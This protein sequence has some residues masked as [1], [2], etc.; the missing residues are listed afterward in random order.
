MSGS[1]ADAGLSDP[2][3]GLGLA[4][5]V[6]I[7]VGIIAFVAGLILLFIVRSKPHEQTSQMVDCN[8]EMEVSEEGTSFE[9]VVMA[10][11]FAYTNPLTADQI[12]MPD[13]FNA[14]GDEGDSFASFFT[15]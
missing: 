11:I 1:N 4:G 10:D 14:L 8:L 2:P 9:T 12:G 15:A 7:G 5:I 13:L 3:G 6:G